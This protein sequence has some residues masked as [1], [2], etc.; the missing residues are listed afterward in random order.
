M[1]CIA[2]KHAEKCV[3]KLWSEIDE[4]IKEELMQI[5]N[6]DYLNWNKTEGI[7]T[8]GDMPFEIEAKLVFEK[9]HFSNITSTNV[10]FIILPFIIST[11]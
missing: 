8:F 4:N 9:L 6:K 11:F 2:K 1:E 5:V 3:D 7:I 10:F